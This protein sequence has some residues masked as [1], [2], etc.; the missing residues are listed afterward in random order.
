M[1]TFLRVS[2]EGAGAR[3]AARACFADARRLDRTFSRFDSASELTRVNGAAGTVTEVTP[4]FARLLAAALRLGDATGHAF[5]ATAGTLTALWRDGR[6]PPAAARRAARARRDDALRLEGRHLR[7]A[8]GVRLD[9]D[10]IAKGWA[11]DACAARLRAAG[12]RR[13][14]VSF[15]ESSLVAIGAPRGADAWTLDVRGPVPGTLAGTLRLRDAAA[16]VSATRTE[17]GPAVGRIVDP[18]TGDAV[19]SHAVAVV[20]AARAT[21]AEALTKALLV[22]GAAGTGRVERLG[23]TAAIHLGAGG[24][25]RGRGAERREAFAAFATS[26]APEAP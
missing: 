12:V 1:G 10:G 21:D 13:A 15:G 8:P 11:T 24:V 16:S 19:G 25:T 5:D 4:E 22:W 18:R 20:T 2:A 6:T 26:I 9:F 14:L 7:L 3:E 17:D 23:A